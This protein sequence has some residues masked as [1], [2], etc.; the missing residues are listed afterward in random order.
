MNR[1]FLLVISM[2]F[3]SLGLWAQKGIELGAWLGTSF[4]FGDLQSEFSFSEPG[5]GAG[6]NFRYNLD[7]R[8]AAKASL[9]YARIHGDDSDSQNSFE[10][11][12]NLSFHSNIIDFTGQFEFNFLPY[13]HGSEEDYFTPYVFAAATV[14]AFSPKTEMNGET[15][16]LRDFGTEGQN[17]GNEYGRFA[18][19]P[20]YGIGL[21]W[22]LNLNWSINIEAGIRHSSTDYLDDVSTRYPDLNNLAQIRGQTAVDLSNRSTVAGIGDTGRQRGNSRNNDTYMIFGISIMRYFGTLECP[23]IVR[24]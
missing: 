15:Y 20:G 5:F 1:I 12:R 11:N 17:I 8:L 16:N 3:I 14:F 19:A 18:F 6:I 24:K 10:R 23:A 22:D 2:V 9:N 13:K 4:Y 21:K 7:E